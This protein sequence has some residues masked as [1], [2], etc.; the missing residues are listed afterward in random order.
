LTK[1]I[2]GQHTHRRAAAGRR[3]VD[4]ER[5]VALTALGERGHQERE[6]GR[7]EHR[8]AEALHG[9]EC[10][11][12]ALRPGEAAQQRAR[13]EHGEAGHEETSPPEQVSQPPTEQQR[14][15]EEDR[16]GRDDPLQARLREAQ[17]GLD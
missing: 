11:Q 13:R 9:A 8:S 3:A 5:D 1:K 10:D 2:H 12:R 15:A 14:P 16:V 7:S 17:V 6:G 4:A